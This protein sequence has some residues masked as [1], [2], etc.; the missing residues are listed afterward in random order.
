MLKAIV[1]A[2]LPWGGWMFAAWL[3]LGLIVKL[4]GGRW[5]WSRL[6]EMHHCESGSVQTLGFVLTLPAF[7]LLAMF[8]VQ[9]SQVM[10][11]IAIV[12]QGAF[13]AARAA[14]V[15]IPATTTL[16]GSNQIRELPNQLDSTDLGQTQFPQWGAIPAQRR[17]VIPGSKT[18]R[19]WRAAVL[20][21]TPAAPSWRTTVQEARGSQLSESL[22]Q[23]YTR[24]VPRTAGNAAMRGRLQRKLD[25]AQW[26]TLVEL[27]GRDANGSTGPTYNPYPGYW[28]SRR[29]EQTGQTVPF[30]VDWNPAELNWEEP[31]TVSVYHN[32]ALLPG[33]GRFL[34]QWLG[35]SGVPDLVSRHLRDMRQANPGVYQKGL[36]VVPLKAHATLQI[37]GLK[38]VIPHVQSY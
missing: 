20:S 9:V 25:Y 36:Y 14:S 16:P 23:F 3:A 27:R 15:W 21:C 12:H 26:N 11:A 24:L 34:S 1:I 30:W 8:I 37:E 28:S 7:M 10:I 4:A 5:R 29:D 33:P 2:W 32:F 18:E 6:R 38:S 31:V 22:F 13:A 19:I 35:G 17:S